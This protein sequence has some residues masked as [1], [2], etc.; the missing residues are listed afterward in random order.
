MRVNVFLTG[1]IA[2]Q[3]TRRD[4]NGTALFPA[5]VPAFVDGMAFENV[6]RAQVVGGGVRFDGHESYWSM[7]CVNTTGTGEPVFSRGWNCDNISSAFD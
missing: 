6:R 2:S 1:P 4:A 3:P 5:I 7:R